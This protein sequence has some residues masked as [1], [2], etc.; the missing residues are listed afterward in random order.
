ML[1]TMPYKIVP[2]SKRQNKSKSDKNRTCRV[3]NANRERLKHRRFWAMNVNRKSKL[4]LFDVYYSL[5]V[6]NYKL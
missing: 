4:L 3:A 6:E 5:L 2:L 1:L